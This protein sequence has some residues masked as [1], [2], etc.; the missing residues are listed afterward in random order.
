MSE[1]TL[2]PKVIRRQIAR[3]LGR[4]RPVPDYITHSKI[5]A[6]PEKGLCA[7]EW[8]E[9]EKPQRTVLF[10]HGGGYFFCNL[11][12]HRQTSCALAGMADARMLSVDY[13]L[14]PEHPFPAAFDD[15]FAWYKELLKTTPAEQITL[16]GDSAGGGLIIACL[17]AARDAG[18]PMPAG[19]TLYSP[20]LD[21]TMSGESIRTKA[22]VEATITV[23]SM[24]PAAEFYL[25]GHDPKD[26]RVSP[27]FGDFTGLPP[28]QT[29]V[30]NHEIFQSDSL[31]LHEKAKAAG[32]D[33][34][35]IRRN[36][37]PHAWPLMQ[38]LPEAQESLKETAKFMK[39]RVPS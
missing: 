9:V 15:C 28:L 5:A 37:L 36:N 13:R 1:G 7:A 3:L 21:L 27:L 18:L 32:V 20:W 29:F 30:S 22:E 35:L 4:P 24:A 23:S 12:T 2:E 11:H 25:Q 33:S 8:L 16:A 38:F 10:F 34:T 19:A 6:Q 14:A 17:M 26:P 39:K 31:R